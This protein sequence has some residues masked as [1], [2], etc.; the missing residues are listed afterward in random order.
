M[1]TSLILDDRVFEDAKKEAEKTGKT[2]SEVVS[3]WAQV[4]REFWKKEQKNKRPKEFKARSLGAPLVDLTNRKNW[5]EELE[6][7][8]D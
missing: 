8:G 5:M 1:K 6:N 7:D 2:I 4:G 3:R